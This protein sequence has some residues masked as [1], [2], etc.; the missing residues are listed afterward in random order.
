MSRSSPIAVAGMAFI[1]PCLPSPARE[2]PSGSDWLHE[3]KWDGFRIQVS[4]DGADARLFTRRGHDWTER[5]PAIVSAARALRA[6]SFLMD[7]EAVCCD[8]TGVP[9]FDM[10]RRRRN[11]AQVFLYA[12][13]LI[14]LA[15]RDLRREPIEMRKAALANLIRDAA[16][17]L[18]LSEHL[19][20]HDG[21]IVFKHVCKLGLEGLVA[22]R[23]GSPYVSGRS[24][25]WIKVK[26]PNSPAV[27]R[28]TEEDWGSKRMTGA[29]RWRLGV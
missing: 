8:A 4:R 29:R 19:D 16:P 3:I 24:P 23:R 5:F 1:E 26:N 7:G 17:G 18:Q 25:D 22:K 15:G 11:D 14:Q 27:R 12:F 2:P 21:A 6:R 20:E 13:D 28:E 9:I 10:L